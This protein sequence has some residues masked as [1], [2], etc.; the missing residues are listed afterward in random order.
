MLIKLRTV[1][2]GNSSFIIR[3]VDTRLRGLLNAE[4]KTVGVNISSC[5]V[6]NVS[7]TVYG[8]STEGA[9]EILRSI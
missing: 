2:T 9:N 8:T 6:S 3:E 7:L 5:H 1:Y 4:R